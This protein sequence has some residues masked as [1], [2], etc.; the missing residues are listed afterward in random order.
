MLWLNLKG[1]VYRT[2]ENV[3]PRLF[4]DCAMMFSCLSDDSPTTMALYIFVLFSFLI[5]FSFYV[6]YRYSLLTTIPK[7]HLFVLKKTSSASSD[8]T[9]MAHQELPVRVL[10]A[11]CLEALLSREGDQEAGF[12]EAA[13]RKNPLRIF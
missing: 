5:H 9:R 7:K 4:H 11:S 3:T 13:A 6:P 2:T 1:T 8:H 10:A 12:E